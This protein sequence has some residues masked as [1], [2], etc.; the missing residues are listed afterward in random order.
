LGNID[1]D[2]EFSK[3][4]LEKF[5]FL[6]FQPNAHEEHSTETQAPFIEH[7][8]PDSK[9]VEIVYGRVGFEKI[10]QI[11]NEVLKESGN[12]VVISTDLSHFYSLDEAKKLDMICLKAIEDLD[13][14]LFDE[15]CEACGIIGVKAMV[16]SALKLDLKAEIL[17]YRTSF[18][19]SGDDKRVVGYTSA[20]FRKKE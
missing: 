6:K 20:L 18:D 19:A 16:E 9:I 13:L 5:D 11:I 2:V 8:F 15:G 14:A 7:F 10:S 4:L 17:D 1:I 3:S 12:L